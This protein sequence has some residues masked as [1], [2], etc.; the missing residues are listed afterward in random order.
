MALHK[1]AA[2]RQPLAAWDSRIFSK[3]VTQGV[4]DPTSVDVRFAMSHQTPRPAVG[5]GDI[6]DGPKAKLWWCGRA[7][8]HRFTAGVVQP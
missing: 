7:R 5:S 4:T 8:C 3:R 1:G 2:G 6:A